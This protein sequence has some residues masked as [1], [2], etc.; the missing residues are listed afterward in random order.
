MRTVELVLSEIVP[1]S[2]ARAIDRQTAVR[3]LDANVI[4]VVHHSAHV[5]SQTRCSRGRGKYARDV[6]MSSG[7]SNDVGA[8][9]RRM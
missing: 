1:M 8:I 7:K 4:S 5:G 3:V 2:Q 6:P 9:I